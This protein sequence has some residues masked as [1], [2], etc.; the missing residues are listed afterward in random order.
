MKKIFLLPVLG[1]CFFSCTSGKSQHRNES[2]PTRS[3]EVP[4]QPKRQISDNI[5]EHISPEQNFENFEMSD[6]SSSSSGNI[7]PPPPN[8]GLK[9]T[10]TEKEGEPTP[11]PE[12]TPPPKE[13]PNEPNE[14]KILLLGW[15][16]S[17]A[18]RK[19]I[20]QLLLG[21]YHSN[22][23]K[24]IEKLGRWFDDKDRHGKKGY[25]FNLIAQTNNTYALGAI[26][27][28]AQEDPEKLKELFNKA[29]RAYLET[30]D[31]NLRRKAKEAMI[32]YKARYKVLSKLYRRL[33]EKDKNYLMDNNWDHDYKYLGG[34]SLGLGGGSGTAITVGLIV[35]G[36]IVFSGLLVGGGIAAGALAIAGLWK[37]GE[38]FTFKQRREK[39]KHLVNS[40]KKFESLQTPK[41][42]N[43]SEGKG[44]LSTNS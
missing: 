39:L 4:S 2:L 32:V 44:E 40:Q 21:L 25:I 14:A 17:I 29:K 33:Q 38:R 23:P 12:H 31:E 24:D 20:K 36:G 34:G 37:A 13:I 16:P 22:D 9:P 6:S 43:T 42:K 30:S 41:E 27:S 5:D 7:V 19:E 18:T 28:I 3:P 35:T 26:L 11:N 1:I 15:K 10:Q 8:D